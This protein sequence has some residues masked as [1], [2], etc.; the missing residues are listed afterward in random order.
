MTEIEGG[1]AVA[2][3]DRRRG[4]HRHRLAPPRRGARR[5]SGRARDGRRRAP[6]PTGSGARRR[7]TAGPAGRRGRGRSSCSTHQRTAATRSWNRAAMR[8]S[9]SPDHCWMR[10]GHDGVGV[11]D[12]GV[13]EPLGDALVLAG[14]DEALDGVGAHDLE[15]PVAGARRRRA[16]RSTSD[17]STRR[18]SRSTTW[19]RSVPGSAATARAR[20]TSNDAG[21]DAQPLQE[22]PLLVLEEIRRHVDGGAEAAVSLLGLRRR[23][24]RAGEEVEA[25]LHERQQLGRRQR[26]GPGGGQLDGERQAVEPAAQR[27]DRR[28]RRR[29]AIPAGAARAATVEEQLHRRRRLDV[30]LADGD[31]E[32]GRARRRARPGRRAAPG[33]WR[34]RAT[35]GRR[36]GAARRRGR[37][38]RGRAR[39]CR[40]RAATPSWARRTAAASGVAQPPSAA[41]ASTSAPDG[42]RRQLAATRR[43]TPKV[44]AA[45]RV[46]PM[47]PGPVMVTS[48]LGGRRARAGAPARRPARRTSSPPSATSVARLTNGRCSPFASRS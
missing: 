39:S 29:R 26:P 12:G 22:A 23:P 47:P 17:R 24:S 42:Q 13:D 46:L 8:A 38:R 20:S 18:P 1:V 34:R 27:A 43:P 11:G 21:E 25:A 28:Q 4:Q 14:A 40:A 44:S 7:G 5:P 19:R 31:G 30:D 10:G 32:R 9:S 15:Q 37:R 35:T 33:W 48:E 2:G 36:R 16:R 45:R 6:P 3:D 41:T